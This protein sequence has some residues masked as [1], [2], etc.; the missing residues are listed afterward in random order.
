MLRLTTEQY[1]EA[2]QRMALAL[3][4]VEAGANPMRTHLGR[5]LVMLEALAADFDVSPMDMGERNDVAEGN[6]WPENEGGYCP[7]HDSLM[8][9]PRCLEERAI[10][11]ALAVAPKPG[12]TTSWSKIL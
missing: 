10:A 5:A 2:A 8:P 9:C 3:A 12:K 4:F 7:M 6:V 1:D 11:A